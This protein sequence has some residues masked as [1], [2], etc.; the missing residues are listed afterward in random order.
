MERRRRCG[1]LLVIL[2]AAMLWTTPPA[3]AQTI[4]DGFPVLDNVSAGALSA[5]SPGNMVS[6]GVA[7]SLAA[8]DFARSPVEITETSTPV[9]PR[10]VFLVDAVEIIF[11][12]IDRAILLFENLLRLRGGLAPAL[13]GGV[14]LPPTTSDDG[15][16]GS[17]DLGSLADLLGG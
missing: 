9:S 6:A 15:E 7:R 2:S 14:T 5:R 8:A 3:T 4:L 12:Q 17:T 10:V 13:P 1:N 11:E 16:S